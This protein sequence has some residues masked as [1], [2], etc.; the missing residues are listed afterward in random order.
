[1]RWRRYFTGW[2]ANCQLLLFFQAGFHVIHMYPQCC[3]RT[4]VEHWCRVAGWIGLWRWVGGEYW[5]KWPPWLTDAPRKPLTGW[6]LRCEGH[7]VKK[8]YVWAADKQIIPETVPTF[9]TSS[10]LPHFVL[11]SPRDFTP[12][13]IAFISRNSSFQQQL[14]A[15][16]IHRLHVRSTCTHELHLS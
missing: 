3:L 2:A 1:M 11:R 16:A 15:R 8:D 5:T 13:S 9:L 6:R 14:R 4:P 12:P 7:R 10:L